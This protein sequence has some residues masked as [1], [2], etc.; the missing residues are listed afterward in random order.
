LLA[1]RLTG[2]L[3]MSDSLNY[4]ILKSGFDESVHASFDQLF[5]GFVECGLMT[6]AFPGV[7]QKT[8]LGFFF[9]EEILKAVYETG[10]T[11]FN[12]SSTFLG[13]SQTGFSSNPVPI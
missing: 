13:K 6:N 9:L 7:V 12:A 4:D 8:E 3:Q 11:P 1:A 10:V 2:A 5:E